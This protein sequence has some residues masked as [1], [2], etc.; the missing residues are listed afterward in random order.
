MKVLFVA[1]LIVGSVL[2]LLLPGPSAAD[3]KKKGPK[4]TVK[5]QP[6]VSRP[7]WRG[8]PSAAWVPALA[9]LV[10][11]VRGISGPRARAWASSALTL[12]LPSFP[13]VASWRL[14][15]P[16]PFRLENDPDPPREP[17]PDPGVGAQDAQ[18]GPALQTQ[19]RLFADTPQC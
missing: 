2:F 17:S 4:V 10:T 19:S 1:A 5:V 6:P 8:L 16:P 12:P 15:R 9:P 7:A 18:L 11:H 13:V 14:G 3:E